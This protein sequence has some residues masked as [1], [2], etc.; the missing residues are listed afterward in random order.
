MGGLRETGGLSPKVV[1]HMFLCLPMA[2]NWTS[3][4]LNSCAKID[5]F[6]T[7]YIRWHVWPQIQDS[8]PKTKQNPQNDEDHYF[9]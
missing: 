6:R 1:Q 8:S 9:N 2:G 4:L 5:D 7:D 3:A